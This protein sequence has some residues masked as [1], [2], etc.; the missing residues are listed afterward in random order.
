M[1]KKVKKQISINASGKAKKDKA[2]LQSLVRRKTEALN[3]LRA[4]QQ[5]AWDAVQAELERTK[6]GMS[7]FKESQ[8]IGAAMDKAFAQFHAGKLSRSEAAEAYRERLD[9]FR[10]KY[11][12]RVRDALWEHADAQPS[13]GAILKTLFDDNKREPLNKLRL[14]V[15][16]WF[17]IFMHPVPVG[18][19]EETTD[20]GTIQQG[21]GDAPLPLGQCVSPPYAFKD[22]QTWSQLISIPVG[23]LATP[24]SGRFF[25]EVMGVTAGGSSAHALVGANFSVPAGY[26]QFVV[27]ADIDWMYDAWSWAAGGVAGTGADLMLRI[28]KMDGSAELDA[29]QSLFSLL[30]PLLWGNGAK[31]GGNSTVTFS[32]TTNNTNARTI[33]V[34]AGGSAHAEVGSPFG[35]SQ[36][37]ASGTVTKICI[38]AS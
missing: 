12:D 25:I 5:P 37:M 18:R 24:N 30:S 23:G 4:L 3:Q 8:A 14:S 10:A 2:A 36:C 13:I 35:G 28:N 38:T 26:S 15:D 27:T 34:L 11:S 29:T 16:D 20:V 31:G 32:F 19:R 22:E 1:K 6:A 7:Y 21:L 9:V 17:G 33:R